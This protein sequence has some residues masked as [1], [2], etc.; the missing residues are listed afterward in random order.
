[1]VATVKELGCPQAD[2]SSSIY[3]SLFQLADGN[4]TYTIASHATDK[5]GGKCTQANKPL[6]LAGVMFKLWLTNRVPLHKILQLPTDAL[7]HTEQLSQPITGKI[8]DTDYPEIA[9]AL[10]FDPNI[11]QLQPS[12]DQGQANWTYKLDPN[13]KDGDY[14]LVILS[15]WQGNLYNWSWF[16]IIVKKQG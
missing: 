10:Q 15:D 6:H 16:D 7:M 2:K 1:M 8:D 11:K 14:S 3:Q 12:N 4:T 5:T 9:N 13:L